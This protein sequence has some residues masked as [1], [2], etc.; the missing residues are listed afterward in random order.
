MK[1]WTVLKVNLLGG[2]VVCA[3]GLSSQSLPPP[4]TALL[5]PFCHFLIHVPSLIH[6]LVHCYRSLLTVSF[7][8]TLGS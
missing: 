8:F 2:R 1:F 4:L 6:T 5:Q 7:Q 3:H